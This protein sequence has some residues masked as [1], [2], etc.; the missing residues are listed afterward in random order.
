LNSSETA[1]VVRLGLWVVATLLLTSAQLRVI[2]AARPR[3]WRYGFAWFGCTLIG[4]AL[5][6]VLDNAVGQIGWTRRFANASVAATI[7]A[8]GLGAGAWL[9][10]RPEWARLR[11]SA[12][13]LTLV[14]LHALVVLIVAY[15]FL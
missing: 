7:S 9:T 3:Q 10:Q 13:F 6:S 15:P 14:L 4:A 1:Q 11:G 12:R 2:P 5:L 8:V